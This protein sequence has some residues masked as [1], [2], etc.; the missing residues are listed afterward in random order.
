MSIA[1]AVRTLILAAAFVLIAPSAT[2]QVTGNLPGSIIQSGSISAAAQ[3]QIQ[4]YV[5]SVTGALAS[6]DLRESSRAREQLLRPLEDRDVSVAF[7]QAYGQSL[8]DVIA[9]HSSSDDVQKQLLALRVAGELATTDSVRII[10]EHMSSDDAGVRL[11]AIGRV[12]RVFEITTAHGPAISSNEASNL[13]SLLTSKADSTNDPIELDG[14]V[15]ALAAGAGLRGSELSGARNKSV[16][17]MELVISPILRDLVPSDD[18]V[19]AYRLAM[20]AASAMTASII[21]VNASTD[22]AS[23]KSS[24]GLAGDILSVP[25]RQIFAGYDL[26]GDERALAVRAVQ[27][28]DALLYFARR[29]Q[30]GGGAIE[31]TSFAAMIEQG[32]DRDYRNAVSLLFDGNSKLVRDNGFDSDRFVTK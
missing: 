3:Q 9:E 26:E 19:P 15:R 5:D 10:R 24:I 22:A 16:Q 7:R 30:P 31:Q 18:T 13:V 6:D 8:A 27:S 1:N 32:E 17:G 4:S 23:L 28:A 21:D 11:F 25:L 29:K 20:R 14:I 2:A 12:Q